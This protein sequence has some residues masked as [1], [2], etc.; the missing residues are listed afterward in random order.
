MGAGNRYDCGIGK[1]ER[2]AAR[3]QI[4][5]EIVASAP[6]GGRLKTLTR[7]NHVSILNRLVSLTK[8]PAVGK[9]ETPP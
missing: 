4:G 6:V 5:V 1:T 2:I 9:I 8:A 7:L 3:E